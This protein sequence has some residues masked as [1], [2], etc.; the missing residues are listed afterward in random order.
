MPLLVQSVLI[1]CQE[2]FTV[3]YRWSELQVFHLYSFNP[4][5]EPWKISGFRESIDNG[6]H[7][8]W[9]WCLDSVLSRSRRC[10]NELCN[11]FNEVQMSLIIPC[12]LYRGRREGRKE[13]RKDARPPVWS[14][15]LQM[16]LLDSPHIVAFI[17]MF[18]Q[19][20]ESLMITRSL[21]VEMKH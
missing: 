15:S 12:F 2:S 3:F 16:M 20:A 19:N 1:V 10:I 18:L 6:E 17:F 21:V 5:S 8:G 13:G 14:N 7:Q 9:L 11:W 4:F